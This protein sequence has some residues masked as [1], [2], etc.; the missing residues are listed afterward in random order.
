MRKEPSER[1]QST[2]DLVVDL[3]LL[4]RVTGVQHAPTLE[5]KAAPRPAR[6]LS[7]PRTWWQIHQV[8]VML[9]SIAMLYPVWRAR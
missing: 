1:Y 5:Q 2:A 8:A 7:R 4:Q 3:E 6:P 9:V